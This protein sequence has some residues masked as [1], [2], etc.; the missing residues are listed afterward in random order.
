MPRQHFFS[1]LFFRGRG[2]GEVDFLLFLFWSFLRV[3]GDSPKS[4]IYVC[5]F[6]SATA[7]ANANTNETGIE[8]T[9]GSREHVRPGDHHGLDGIWFVPD[10]GRLHGRGVRSAPGGRWRV[11]LDRCCFN[12]RSSRERL[13]RCRRDARDCR[14]YSGVFALVDLS[15]RRGVVV[16]IH[17][18]PEAASVLA[19]RLA[20]SVYCCQ[21]VWRLC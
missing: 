20:Y 18:T 14:G 10:H 21:H 17:H 16:A 13:R 8:E 7:N 15:R 1:F 9:R 4:Y 19:I 3:R 2:E 5:S 12:G 6:C 11:W